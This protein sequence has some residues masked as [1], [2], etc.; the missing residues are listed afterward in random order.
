MQT[1]ES[2][3]SVKLCLTVKPATVL[4]LPWEAESIGLRVLKKDFLNKRLFSL[5]I[6]EKS[7]MLCLFIYL[8]CFAPQTSIIVAS[9]LV[10][11][12]CII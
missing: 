12:H 11:V 3:Q 1:F 4:R 9:L 2:H 10:V 5:L 8:H 7:V 6:K